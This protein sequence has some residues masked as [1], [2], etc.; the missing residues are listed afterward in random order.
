M[1]ENVFECP[2]C[3]G[4]FDAQILDVECRIV[5]PVAACPVCGCEAENRGVIYEPEI[6]GDG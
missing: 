3:G 1:P 4:V 2:Q 6:G 5:Q